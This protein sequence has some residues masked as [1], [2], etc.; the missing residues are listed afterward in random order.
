M[1]LSVSLRP[2][3]WMCDSTMS[4]DHYNLRQLCPEINAAR[5]PLEARASSGTVSVCPAVRPPAAG[6]VVRCV[7]SIHGLFDSFPIKSGHI[8][9]YYQ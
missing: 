4:R 7:A 6:A 3:R 8:C 2:G 5:Y 9:M 1:R